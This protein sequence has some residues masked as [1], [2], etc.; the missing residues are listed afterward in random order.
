[1]RD[2]WEAEGGMWLARMIVAAKK[3]WTG[4]PMARVF[5]GPIK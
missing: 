3:K 1:M 4:I 2:K 5:V